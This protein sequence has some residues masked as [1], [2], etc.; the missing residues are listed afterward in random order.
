M[1]PVHGTPEDAPPRAIAVAGLGIERGG[2]TIIADLNFVVPRGEAMLLTGPNGA[3]KSSLLLALG[4]FIRPLAGRIDYVG[5]DAETRP[6]ADVHFIGHRPAIKPRLTARENLQFMA[7][8]LGGPV[9]DVAAA[10]VTVGLS[11]AADLDAG[12]LSA[13]QTRRLALARLLVAPRPFW[14]LDEPTAALD[15]EGAGLVARLIDAHLADGGVVIAA[16]HHDLGLAANPESLA[17]V[18]LE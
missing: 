14:L 17:L 11:H 1:S 3:G 2:R 10:L 13:G 4:G 9:G 15:D 12:Y 8:L 5:R 16:T 6:F 18:A 7:A